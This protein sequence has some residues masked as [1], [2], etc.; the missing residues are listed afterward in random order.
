MNMVAHGEVTLDTTVAEITI[1]DGSGLSDVTLRELAS[2][3]SGLPDFT[4]DQTRSRNSWFGLLHADG[5]RQDAA[6]T[7]SE[8]LAQHPES[9]GRFAYSTA[10][11]APL[12]HR[13]ATTYQQLLTQRILQPLSL[14]DTSLPI[15]RAGLPTGRDKGLTGTALLGVVL[16][17]V[18]MGA[19]DPFPIWLGYA[20]L[21][22]TA[23]TVLAWRWT[24]LKP[25]DGSHPGLLTRVRPALRFSCDVHQ[26]LPSSAIRCST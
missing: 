10:G 22:A 14:T 26:A 19:L 25:G 1:A 7:V 24:A 18:L 13:A 4:A 11:I 3:T 12:A 17:A 8:I 9:Q 21:T 15:T 16:P 2:H 23:A 20:V 6:Q 5:A